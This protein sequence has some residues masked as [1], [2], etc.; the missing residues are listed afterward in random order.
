[1][2]RETKR[3][4]NE[5]LQA[6]GTITILPPTSPPKQRTAGEKRENRDYA[7]YDYSDAD[8]P[9]PLDFWSR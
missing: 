5:Y 6:G 7:M 4:I 2:D 3:L 1:M 8:F 9:T